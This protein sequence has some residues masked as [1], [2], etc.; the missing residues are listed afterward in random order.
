MGLE[1]IGRMFA[2]LPFL[3][4]TLAPLLLCA[5]LFALVSEC[6]QITAHL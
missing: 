3:V 1:T 4:A 5:V 2:S 6:S